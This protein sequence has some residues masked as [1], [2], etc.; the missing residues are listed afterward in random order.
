MTVEQIK[1][2]LINLNESVDEHKSRE[3]FRTGAELYPEALFNLGHDCGV[4][5][6]CN[7]LLGEIDKGVESDES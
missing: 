1:R 4:K 2:M 5:F 3:I 6:V 7:C